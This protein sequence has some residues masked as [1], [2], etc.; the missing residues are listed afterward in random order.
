VLIEERHVG[1]YCVK[2]SMGESVAT[3]PQV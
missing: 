2:K 3:L 1:L